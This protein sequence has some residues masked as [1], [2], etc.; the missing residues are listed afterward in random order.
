[1]PKDPG[2]RAGFV[3]LAGCP[4]VGK[5]TLLNHL[6]GEPVAIVTPRPQTTR[7]TIRGVLTVPGAQ[8]VFLDTPGLHDP[9]FLLNET[10][11][12]AA[13]EAIA[14]VDVVL[15]VVDAGRPPGARDREVAGLCLASGRPVVLV[16]NKWDTVPEADAGARRAEFE[17]LG[18]FAA[19][20]PTCAR[21]ADS[22]AEVLPHIVP[23]LPEGPPFYPE[24]E[25]T[26]QTLRDL[27]AERVRE[28]VILQ[29]AEEIPYAVAVGIDRYEE[30]PPQDDGGPGGDRVWATIYVER[31]S[32]KGILIGKGGRRIKA[33]GTA[34]R[35]RM[36]AVTG[37]PVHLKLFVKVRPGWRKDRRFLREMGYG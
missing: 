4:N 19:V 35:H 10:M 20:V 24:D 30:A 8:L 23:R 12:R 2:H 1:V 3:A 31:E 11:V 36:E 21:S 33:I 16:L 14:E 37:A 7:R 29:C 32:Q 28:Q 17:A 15:L 9:K 34:A 25:L 26:D 6:L 13:R 27:V 18:S 5:S 22:A